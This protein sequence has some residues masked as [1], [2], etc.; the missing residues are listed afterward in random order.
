MLISVKKRDIESALNTIEKSNSRTPLKQLNT[1][2]S[3]PF[4]RTVFKQFFG[5][6]SYATLLFCLTFYFQSASFIIH[7]DFGN[8]EK[9]FSNSMKICLQ[10][11]SGVI[12]N[13]SEDGQ[14]LPRAE[15]IQLLIADDHTTVLAGLVSIL[16]MQ[17]DMVVVA[18]ASNGNQALELWQKHVP[19]VTLVDLRM[20]KLNGVAVL[21]EIHK[22]NPSARVIVLTTYD[23]DNDICQAIKAGAKGY[24]L[25]DARR[26]ELLECIRKV[27]C[28][29]TCIPQELVE[30]LAAGMSSEIL[31]GREVEVLKLLARGKSNK[32]IGTNLYISETTVKGH[33]RNIFTKLKVLSRTEAV[34]VASRRGLVQL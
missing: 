24:I 14:K 25:K 21:E 4:K 12:A 20:P 18:E 31:T 27:S 11:P 32:E 5:V 8:S 22:L 10:K 15:K 30:K 33:L 28:G 9:P 2:K 29:G 16:N 17:S 19:D 6:E 7:C 3:Y 1:K 26:E 13:R 23:T 34:T